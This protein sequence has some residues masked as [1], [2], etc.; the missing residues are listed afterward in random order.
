MK[1]ECELAIEQL[2][3]PEELCGSLVNSGFTDDQAYNIAADVYQPLAN[4][5]CTLNDKINELA[6]SN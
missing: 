5:I 3:T 6:N 4:I 1:F 2:P